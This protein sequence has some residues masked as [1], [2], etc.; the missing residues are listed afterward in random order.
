MQVQ[1]ENPKAMGWIA[2]RG[3][4]ETLA[5]VLA[6]LA[7][8]PAIGY[9]FVYDDKPQIIENPAIHNWTYLPKY[10]TSHAWSE[11]YP[12]VQGNYY[13]P[14][15]LL[16]F[17]LNHA[18]FG[19]DPKG[20]HLTSI[21]CHVAAVFLVFVLIL[22]LAASRSIAFTAATLFAL[23]P[24]HIES[25]AWVSGV[26]DPLMT[27]LT[28]G[29]FLAF[30]RFGEDHRWRW[31]IGS[32]TLFALG[33]LE[34]ETAI[35]L[36]PLVFIY[37]WLYAEQGSG[38]KRFL[39]TLK[40]ASGFVALA[41]LYLPL[42]ALVLRGFSHTVSPLP[43]ATMALTEPSIVWLY[44]HHLLFPTGISGLYG[45]PYV[46]SAMSTAFVIPAI[47]LIASL[48]ALGSII[49]RLEDT[50][51]ALFACC[52]MVLPILPVL[53]LRA[54]AEGDIAHD[55][56][57]YFPSVGFV[58][59]VSIILARLAAWRR[60][61][62]EVL[63]FGGVAIIAVAYAFGTISQQRFWAN[64]LELYQRAYSIAPH[65]NLICND[66]GAALM[67]AGDPDDAIALY[68]KVLAR[69]P[70][71][72]LS[73]YNLGYTYYKIGKLPEA[74][75]YLRRAVAINT[76][77][78]DEYLYLGLSIWRQGRPDDAVPCLQ[79]AIQIR[80][81]APGYHFALA[82]VRHDQHDIPAAES[83]L[84]LEIQYHPESITARQ[85]LS[86]LLS[87]GATGSTR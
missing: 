38:I 65:D 22:R 73:N 6:F 54:Y 14:L 40:Q 61:N 12:N 43:L 20:W 2:R 32:L 10:F 56:Y 23:H 52:W 55:R 4:A 69:E 67:D 37:V 86:T 15:F 1:A 29:S 42:R 63:E 51:L 25:V 78:S 35:I 26:T 11:L 39:F 87:G 75:H 28:I 13:R 50:R 46:R 17:R 70:G 59:L 60:T 62:A 24:I 30:L 72:W 48:V 7:Y 74:E 47:F 82:M 53:W 68:S 77:D 79:R 81:T 80:P 33:L 45:L 76:A 84:N 36:G 9:Q 3:V 27:I 44:V 16:W 64:D 66:L 8:I 85:Q 5:C 41:I 71:F 57:L 83:E 18:L 34:K 49:S 21:L 19:L 58:L 31:M